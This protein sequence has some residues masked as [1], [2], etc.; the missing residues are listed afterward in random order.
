[1]KKTADSVFYTRNLKKKNLSRKGA[2]Y[3]GIQ[4][5]RRP[6]CR[7]SAR[8]GILGKIDTTFAPLP[9][10]EWVYLRP[11]ILT[12]FEYEHNHLE[13]AL[14][15]NTEVFSLLTEDSRRRPACPQA[16]DRPGGEGGVFRPAETGIP[17]DVMDG[18]RNK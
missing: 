8:P 12:C 18:I 11:C 16:T 1:M 6:S 7:R 5:Q 4:H 15:Q 2:H 9:G 17:A 10:A 14:T 3:V 13:T